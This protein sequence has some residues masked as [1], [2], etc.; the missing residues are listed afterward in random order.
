MKPLH[1]MRRRISHPAHWRLV[2]KLCGDDLRDGHIRRMF[3]FPR[4]PAYL[5][6]NITVLWGLELTYW[7][8]KRLLSVT[9][10]SR[11]HHWVSWNRL[12]LF[13]PVSNVNTPNRNRLIKFCWNISRSHVQYC[14]IFWRIN[15]I[16][17]WHKY[18]CGVSRLFIE[19]VLYNV[20]MWDV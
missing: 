6:I 4:L 18:D 13:G 19:N 5:S 3:P 7:W 17:F 8:P 16:V 1:R 15:S 20:C 14:K 12:L 10:A 11:S 9:M 2:L